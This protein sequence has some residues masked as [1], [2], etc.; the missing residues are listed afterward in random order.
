[1]TKYVVRNA[2]LAQKTPTMLCR[3]NHNVIYLREKVFLGNALSFY[4]RFLT[5][6]PPMNASEGIILRKKLLAASIVLLGV[7]C[8]AI[9]LF[10]FNQYYTTSAATSQ[11]LKQLDA[12]S[13]GNA[14][15]SI[16]FSTAD[17]AATRTATENTLNSLLFSAF[18]DFA[19]GAILFAAG[20]VMT[21]RESH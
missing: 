9:G 2:M 11:T 14:A 8:I 17:L 13:S 18:A 10:Q 16:G 7:L 4:K 5:T 20:Y 6:R 15:E 12:L 1:M 3:R 19:L 21:P